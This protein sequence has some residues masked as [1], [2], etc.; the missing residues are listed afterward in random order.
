MRLLV[1]GGRDFDDIDFIVTRLNALHAY[2][3]ITAIV[4]GCAR[5][6]DTISGLWADE[7]NVTRIREPAKWDENGK[8]AGHIRNQL[9]LDKHR[10]DALMAFPGGTGTEDMVDRATKVL[11]EIWQS[12]WLYF[13]GYRGESRT[14]FMSN[15]AE[16][17]SFEDEEGVHWPTSEHY[18]QAMK[19]PIESERE[20]VREC[21]TPGKAKRMGGKDINVTTDWP[22]R[23]M[24]V[25]RKVI[26]YKFAKGTPA[27]HALADTG[28]DYLVEYA[29]WGDTFWGVG[30]D[31]RGSNWLGKLLMEQRETL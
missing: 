19:S 24:Q 17:Y 31:Y 7:V 16:D 3:P 12:N 22:Q 27:A 11:Q 1:T 21:A 15:F 18:Y 25:M 10:P 20:M 29:P 5:G 8:V 23:K 28:I 6:A 26:Q 30:K 13:G 9:M 4:E 14:G 2:R